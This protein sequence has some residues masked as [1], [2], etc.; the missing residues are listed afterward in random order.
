MKGGA[1]LLQTPDSIAE[2]SA[3]DS[4]L[5]LP[6]PNQFPPPVADDELQRAK[7]PS[8]E[9]LKGKIMALLEGPWSPPPEDL[10][11]KTDLEKIGNS[12]LPF[13]KEP[14]TPES[15]LLRKETLGFIRKSEQRERISKWSTV[16]KTDVP[17][18][19]L[20]APL[21][22]LHKSDIHVMKDKPQTTEELMTLASWMK[23]NR[24]FVDV[25]VI[26]GDIITHGPDD[27]TDKAQKALSEIRTRARFGMFVLG[28]HDYH[29]HRSD[30]IRESLVE[31]GYTDLNNDLAS[32]H[33]NGQDIWFHGIEDA[34]F[35][36]PLPSFPVKET[37]INI[38]LGHNNDALRAN[39][40][41][42][43]DFMM[44]GHTHWGEIKIFDGMKFMNWWGYSDDVNGHTKGW[45][46]YSD[47]LISAI[48]PGL[49]RYYVPHYGLR[50][51]P[52]FMIHTLVP[53]EET[54]SDTGELL[55]N[56]A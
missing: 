21:S 53:K 33:V 16:F 9:G 26:T 56:V 6:E 25:A 1:S 28:N 20:H 19:N 54:L 22:I 45:D 37:N 8:R 3:L 47:R 5:I 27:L 10:P 43:F 41:D 35:G 24:V 4:G 50:H 48:S 31:L 18:A 7:L 40:D 11:M 55:R 46:M 14:K 49:A 12:A 29:G 32:I 15:A 13:R 44:S 36:S 39:Y 38:L 23:E 30:Y 2:L 34:Y 42:A 17:I 51:P 52:G